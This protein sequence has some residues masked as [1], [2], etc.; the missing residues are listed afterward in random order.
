MGGPMC[1]AVGPSVPGH[2]RHP[3]TS[4]AHRCSSLVTSGGQ[5]DELGAPAPR[6][7]VCVD[8][9]LVDDSDSG[10]GLCRL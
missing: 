8:G 4:Q 10:L 6:P 2:R 5:Q 9:E 3:C 7:A 1:Q